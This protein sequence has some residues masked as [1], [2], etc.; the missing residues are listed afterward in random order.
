M[1]KIFQFTAKAFAL[2]LILLLTSCGGNRLDVDVSDVNVQLDIRHFETDLFENKMN[3]LVE[4]TA[5]YPYFI[6]DYTMG[7]LGFAPDSPAMAFNQL[8]LYKTDVNVKK[9]YD[10]VKAKY[11]NFQTY[12]AQL[13]DVYKHFK[14]YF[15]DEK[16]PTIVTYTS[17][18]SFYMNPVGQDYIGIALDMHMGSDFKY[19]DYAEI[20]KYW[21]KILIPESIVPNHMMAHANDLFVK[22]HRN[23]NFIDEMIYYGKLLYFIDAMCPNVPDYIKIGMTKQE[24]EWCQKEEHNIWSFIVKEKYLYDTERRNFEKL[25]REGPRTQAAGVPEQAPAM[26]GRFAGWMAV[27][28][29]MNENSNVTLSNLMND[30]NAEAILQ[31]S[32]YK[33]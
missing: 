20:E 22:T 14:Y 17:N 28:Q 15:P 18:F 32:G 6:S 13:T 27:R 1:N 11:G 9:V 16:I 3:N 10:L 33:P 4:F 29:Y 19:Y 30:G 8:M 24:F 12:E 26:I 23:K 7:I 25:V 31:K 21:R 2:F 5:K